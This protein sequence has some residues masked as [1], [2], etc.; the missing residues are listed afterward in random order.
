MGAL[1]IIRKRANECI[2]SSPCPSIDSTNYSYYS[3]QFDTNSLKKP[4][5]S[6]LNQLNQV[7]LEKVQLQSTVSRLKKYPEPVGKLRREVH[8]PCRSKRFRFLSNSS[9]GGLKTRVSETP[10]KGENIMGNFFARPQSLRRAYES[11]KRAAFD[12]LQHVE[13]EKEAVVSEDLSEVV[14]IEDDNEVRSGDSSKRRGFQSNE[15]GLLIEP[16]E[17]DARVLEKS[18]VIDREA[19]KKLLSSVDKKYSPKLQNLDFEIKSNEAKLRAVRSTRKPKEET[20]LE[21]PKKPEEDLLRELF[22]PL[23][24]EEEGEVKAAF[25][26]SNRRKI[27]VTHENSNIQIT[28][29]KLQCLLPGAWLN[30]DVINVYLELLKE[31]ERREPEKYLTCHF[32]NTFF[33]KKLIGGRNGYDYKAVKRWTT[34]RKLGYKLSE[35]DKIFVPIHKEVHWCLAVINNKDKTFQYLDSLGG[36]DSRVLSVLANYYV[37]EVKDKSGQD[38]DVNSWD[39]EYVEDLPEQQNGFDCGVFMIK[40][41]DFYSRGMGLHFSQENMPYFRRRT[42]KE[43]LRLQAQ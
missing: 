38:I 18:V 14:I 28:G 29:E 31:R 20:K 7:Q 1:T 9:E 16:R 41:A 33:Y 5:I 22:A 39:L 4:R 36:R 15:L 2:S 11:K 6:Y 25:S 24:K 19:Y 3:N 12:S 26:N 23:S 17:L 34:L 40:Y 13:V 32:F 8:A 43:I 30:D 42:A 21:E 10:K 35:C 37:D 27:L